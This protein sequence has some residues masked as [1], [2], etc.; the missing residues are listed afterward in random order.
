MAETR[1]LQHLCFY[2]T[3]LC[4]SRIHVTVITIAPPHFL[5]DFIY[6]RQTADRSYLLIIVR[7]GKKALCD[8]TNSCAQ[9][10]S[11]ECI[12]PTGIIYSAGHLDSEGTI[13][14]RVWMTRSIVS[15]STGPPLTRLICVT[16]AFKAHCCWGGFST[17]QKTRSSPS[18][19]HDRR[20]VSYLFLLSEVPG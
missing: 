7:T 18:L 9:S 4:A 13:R 17:A 19:R 16:L 2:C 3:L 12:V 14:L 20:I 5:K 1:I 10:P 11:L 8:S 15:T 6:K